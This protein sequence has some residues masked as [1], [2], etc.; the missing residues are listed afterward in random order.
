MMIKIVAGVV[1]FTA[2]TPFCGAGELTR[3]VCISGSQITI[4]AGEYMASCK[5]LTVKRAVQFTVPDVTPVKIK[6]EGMVLPK[7]PLNPGIWNGNGRLLKLRIAGITACGSLDPESVVVVRKDR[8]PLKDNEDYLLEKL[9]GRIVM[10]PSGAV[11]D[12][13]PVFVSYTCRLQRLDTVAA[14]VSGELHYVTGEPAMIA[15][16]LP[17][18]PDGYTALFNVYRPYDSSAVLKEHFFPNE[19]DSK[20]VKTG[21]TAGC[22]P[23]TL[24]KLKAGE[25]VKIVCWGDSVTV[26]ADLAGQQE[27]YSDRLE[28]QL[29]EMFPQ[30][31]ITVTNI[32]IGGT[33]SSHWLKGQEQKT[34]NACTFARVLAAKPDLVTIEFVND[35]NLP[36]SLH[37][38]LYNRIVTEL[39]A[40]GSELILITP[41]FTHPVLMGTQDLRTKD[42]RPYVQFLKD[43]SAK[44]SIALADASARWENLYRT[45]IP[46]ITLLA[47]GWNHPDTRGH[48]F[49]AEELMKCFDDSTVAG[50]ISK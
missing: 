26:G 40:I 5:S 17:V 37:P 44:N 6:D 19:I 30:A 48:A 50:G 45:G 10:G 20:T 29:K 31:D 22:I 34:T 2:L 36:G 3:D 33:Q 16:Q 38:A 21:S 35:A 8:T 13:E 7:S 18:L 12:K 46:Y 47:N 32:S 28:K 41:H 15:P 1:C 9:W 43:F 24:A 4:P 11:A 23:K 27:R 42:I 14:D 25:P 49:F 39:S